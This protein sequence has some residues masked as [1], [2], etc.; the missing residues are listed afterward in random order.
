MLVAL[1]VVA[2]WALCV[3]VTTA[4][5]AAARRGDRQLDPGREAALVVPARS[6]PA[7]A[8]EVPVVRVGGDADADSARQPAGDLA[9]QSG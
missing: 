1:I 7:I 2:S 8:P 6:A 3:V 5:C 9:L 4:L